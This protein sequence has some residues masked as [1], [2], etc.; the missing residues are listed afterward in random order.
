LS[1]LTVRAIFIGSVS[2]ALFN[3]T[4]GQ[5]DP[6]IDAHDIS[7]KLFV[8]VKGSSF[9]DTMRALYARVHEIDGSDEEAAEFYAKN[10]DKY[11]GYVADYALVARYSKQFKSIEPRLIVSSYN[12]RNDVLAFPY[13]DS[14]PFDK[15][16]NYGILKLQDTNLAF[17]ICH[18]YVGDNAKNCLM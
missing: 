7:G 11:D 4:I 5:K 14:F 10:T 6:F 16:F 18:T 17:S 13:N 9:V 3:I 12:V 1:G 2:Y 8:V 15:E